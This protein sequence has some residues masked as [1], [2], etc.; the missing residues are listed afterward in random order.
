MVYQYIMDT[1]G[2]STPEIQ[3]TILFVINTILAIIAYKLGFAKKLPLLKSFFVY[4][5]LIVGIALLVF[6]FQFLI[7]ALTDSQSLPL[8]ESLFIICVILGIY[9]FRLHRERKTEKVS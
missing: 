4:M 9:R 8:T 5:L 2:D 6:T 1:F 7:P 3:F